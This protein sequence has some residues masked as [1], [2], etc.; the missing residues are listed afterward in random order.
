MSAIAV[1]VVASAA[2]LMALYLTQSAGAEI[3]TDRNAFVD[4]QRIADHIVALTYQQQLEAFRYLQDL[5]EEHR[6]AFDVRGDSAEAEMQL[7]LFQQLS[8]AARLE[9]ERMKEAHQQFEVTAHRVLELAERGERDEAQRRNAQLAGGA[10][11]LDS[12]VTGFLLARIAQ[13]SALQTRYAALTARVRVSL[14]LMGVAL[15]ALAGIL[16]RQLERRVLAPLNQLIA[17]AKQISGGDANARVPPQKYAELEQ[18]ALSFNDMAA[19]IHRARE[20]TETQNDELRESL[21]QL[22][23]AQGELVQREKLSA[24]GQMLAGLAHEL[25]NPLAS[26]LGIAELLRIEMK[27]SNDSATRHLGAE[28]AEPLAREAERARD[29]VRNLLSF[30]RKS[31]GMAEPVALSAAVRIAMGLRASAFTQAGKRLEMEV[32]PTLYVMA[33]VQKLEHIIINVANNSLDAM[34]AASGTVLRI[35]ATQDGDDRVRLVLEDDGPG[36][37]NPA[38]VFDAFYT[39]KPADQGTGLGLTLVQQFVH[40]FGGEVSAENREGGGARVVVRMR[41]AKPPVQPD[42]APAVNPRIA[43]GSHPVIP[44]PQP[45]RTTAVPRAPG[46]RRRILIV[47]DEASLREIQRRLLSQENVDVL[48]ASNAEEAQQTLLTEPVDLVISDLR[49]P[50]RTDG[51]GLMAWIDATLPHLTPYTLVVSGDTHGAQN[52]D[53]ELPST[54]VLSKPFTRDEYL[55]RVRALLSTTRD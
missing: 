9:V 21:D 17:V 30:S 45:P 14:A 19:S 25:N 54:R 12:S 38:A 24:M 11:V 10:A 8:P 31:S 32:P 28:L 7:Y 2:T 47:D 39:T 5:K 40:E 27:A 44:R 22:H 43:S 16:S 1:V 50:G 35:S 52:G 46:R 55:S 18:V 6:R 51:R 37:A 4:E 3:E 34:S 20:T 48:L 29:L 53:L 42:L 36:F 15:L 49:M 41:S 33:D 23:R 26:V 13:R